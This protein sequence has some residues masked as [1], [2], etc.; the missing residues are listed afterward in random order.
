MNKGAASDTQAQGERMALY[1]PLS[2]LLWN[3]RSEGR[4]ESRFS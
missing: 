1:A 4:E 2:Q 3:S